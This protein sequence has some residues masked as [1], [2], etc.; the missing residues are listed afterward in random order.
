MEWATS[1]P[2][3]SYNFAHIPV[4]SAID[5]FWEQK[6]NALNSANKS[7]ALVLPYLD[8]HMP[9][10]TA[11]GFVIGILAFVF[12][13]AMVWHIWWL[14]ILGLGGVLVSLIMRSFDYNTDYYITASEVEAN[15]IKYQQSILGR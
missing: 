15:E 14:S 9:R 2:V 1:S 6:E 10:N 4:V 13:F 12:S 8:I 5:S 11:M 7:K 3:A